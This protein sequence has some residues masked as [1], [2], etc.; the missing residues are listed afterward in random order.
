[1]FVNDM[2]IL[3]RNMKYFNISF[4]ITLV[5]DI[6]MSVQFQ[7]FKEVNPDFLNLKIHALTYLYINTL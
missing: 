5:Y 2:F 1:M 3:L 6:Y 4:S 7:V